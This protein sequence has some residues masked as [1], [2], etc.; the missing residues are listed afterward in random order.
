[1]KLFLKETL[2][3]M[4]SRNT[5]I[6]WFIPSILQRHTQRMLKCDECNLAH[7]EINIH[8][9]SQWS[10]C[11][12]VY[13][14]VF[15]PAPSKCPEFRWNFLRCLNVE[16]GNRLQNVAN[17][18]CVW[19]SAMFLLYK[20]STQSLG[21]ISYLGRSQKLS[22]RPHFPPDEYHVQDSVKLAK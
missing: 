20:I 3:N 22:S 8:I 5:E 4:E 7:T 11:S 16:Q 12:L 6:L 14:A 15:I 10:S 21:Q 13:S 18:F 9:A 2:A 1:M 17:A 19:K